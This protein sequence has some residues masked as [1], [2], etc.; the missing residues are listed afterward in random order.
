MGEGDSSSARVSASFSVSSSM[1]IK[2]SSRT[3]YS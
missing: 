1:L 3:V 2:I